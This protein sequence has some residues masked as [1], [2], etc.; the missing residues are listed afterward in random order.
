[1]AGRA[2]RPGLAQDEDSRLRSRHP[3]ALLDG[4]VRCHRSRDRRIHLLLDTADH[5]VTYARGG[6]SLDFS[7]YFQAGMGA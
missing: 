7:P 5:R 6:Q 1:M 4:D 2:G 3:P